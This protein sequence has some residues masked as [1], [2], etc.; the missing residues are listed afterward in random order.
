MKRKYIFICILFLLFII[1]TILVL[2]NKYSVIDNNVYNYIISYRSNFLDSIFKLITSIGNTMNIIIIVF[3]LLIFLSKESIYRLMITIITTVSSNQ[4]LKNIIRKPRP[5]ILRLIK[6]Y[7]Y[8]YPSGHTMISVAVFG[9]LIYIVN[10][11]IKNK[12]IKVILIILLLSLILL[13]G[14]S[15][16]YLGVHDFSDVVGGYLL[17]IPILLLT[18][19]V[20]SNHFR[21][22]INDKDSSF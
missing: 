8:S 13:I 2:T 1:N 14:V 16:I 7:G 18:N 11:N 6:E 20:L 22:N 21:G 17:T 9:V 10:R 19:T 3:I 15:R 4:I 5:N 12:F